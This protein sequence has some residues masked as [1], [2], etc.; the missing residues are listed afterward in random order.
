MVT[1]DFEIFHD[2]TRSLS[3]VLVNK[4]KGG[5]KL[6]FTNIAL[7]F[8]IYAFASI[9]LLT[10][11]HSHIQS[12]CPKAVENI[13]DLGDNYQLHINPAPETEVSITVQNKYFYQIWL[14]W[15]L[16]VF[17]LIKFGQL[18]MMIGEPRLVPYVPVYK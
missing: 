14:G 7:K 3:H 10:S 12:V 17:A 18:I 6:T 15:L 8:L 16:I 13:T 4:K 2:I 9:A 1:R 11:G 5:L